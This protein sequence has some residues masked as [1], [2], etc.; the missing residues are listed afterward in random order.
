MDDL[1]RPFVEWNER[2]AELLRKLKAERGLKVVGHLLPDVPEELIHSCGAI[3][4]A[5]EGA[6]TQASLAKAHMPS[7]TCAHAMGVLEMGLRGEL[8]FLDALIIPYLC[9]TT[10]NLS[11]IWMRA[12]HGIPSTLLR[13]PKKVENPKAAAYLSSELRR[14]AG[15]LGSITS[16][17]PDEGSLRESV[18]LYN[19]SREMLRRAYSMHRGGHRQWGAER[20]FTLLGSAIRA[21]REEH[22]QWMEALPW[23]ES[24][25]E[26]LDENICIYVRGK[27]W[28]P[29]E[30]LS[31]FDELGILI[32]ADEMVTGWRSIALDVPLDGDPWEGVVQRHLNS[33]PYPGYHVEPRRVIKDFLKRVKDSGA[34]GVLFINPKFCEEAGFETPELSRALEGEGIPYLILETSAGGLPMGQLRVRIEAF[35]EILRGG[36]D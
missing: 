19:R 22:I 3:P 28:D 27:V 5:L 34:Q 30:I 13:L 14:L 29:P 18:A 31:L 4:L 20:I 21:P 32:T 35:A 26:R 17:T 33:I 25:G 6:R 1:W 16:K 36:M 8:D 12:V 2:S 24:K 15:F 11:H 7:Y 23:N 10:R 9:D